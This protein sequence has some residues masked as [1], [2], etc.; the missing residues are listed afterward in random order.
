MR[1]QEALEEDPPIEGFETLFSSLIRNQQAY[2]VVCCCGS[3]KC[4]SAVGNNSPG[5]DDLPCRQLLGNWG[6]N[7]LS[8][9]TSYCPLQPLSRHHPLKFE[10]VLT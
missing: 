3:E 1:S 4:D 5:P 10:T 6:R 9:L 7:G 8:E 2:G